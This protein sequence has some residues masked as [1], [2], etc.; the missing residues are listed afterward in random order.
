MPIF[1]WDIKSVRPSVCLSV[2]GLY[3]YILLSKII[4]FAKKDFDQCFDTIGYLK[5]LSQI[6]HIGLIKRPPYETKDL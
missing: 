6:L 1:M 2:T 5:N 3:T 4:F